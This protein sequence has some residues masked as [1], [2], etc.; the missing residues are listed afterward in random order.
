[1]KRTDEIAER[2]PE[3]YE[4][5]NQKGY[6][7]YKSW[8]L[9]AKKRLSANCCQSDSWWRRLLGQGISALRPEGENF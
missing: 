6:C 1:M 4:H 3:L 5:F 2:K 9:W 8:R 7:R